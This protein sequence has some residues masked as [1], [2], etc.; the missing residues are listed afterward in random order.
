MKQDT[1]WNM[2][3]TSYNPLELYRLIEKTTLAQTEDQYPFA[4]VY[5]HELNFYSFWQETMSNPQWYEKFNTKVDVG[6]A[7]GVT[8][9]H[10]VLLEYVAQENHTLTFAALSAE[11]KQAVREDAEKRYI[12]YAFLRQSGAQH[13]NLK[14]DLRNDF[15]TGSNRYPKTCQQTLH[16]LDKYSKTVVVPKMT[17]SEGSSF[18]QKVGRGGRGGK[19]RATITSNK[20]YWE[21]KTCFNCGEKG[22]PSSSCTKAAVTNDDNSAS[23][24]QSV[25][26]LAKDTKNLKKAF[27]QLQKTTEQDLDLSGSESEEED[28]HFQFGNGFQFTQMKVKQT[29]IK[30]EPRIAKLFK[31]THGTKIKLDLQKVILLD[32]QSTMDL[33]CDPVLVELTFKSSHSMRLKS[34]GRTMEVKKQAIMPGYHAHVW[35]NKKQLPTFYL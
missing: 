10:K 1:N 4:T 13:G 34:N 14:V 17:S 12:S 6:S 26:K 20:E 33:I 19:G 5:D 27:T 22:H 23:I 7:I 30:F 2:T 29:A 25:K 35:Y 9:L 15:T 32:S 28:S 16:L 21:D 18:A 31:Q 3:S 24:A 8:R 11:Q